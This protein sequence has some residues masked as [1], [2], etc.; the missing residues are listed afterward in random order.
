MTLVRP[1]GGPAAW[2][3]EQIIDEQTWV[4][5]CPDTVIRDLH[6][7][8]PVVVDR[9]ERLGEPIG[10][11]VGVLGPT[12]AWSPGLVDLAERVRADLVDGRGFSLVRGVPVD[13]LS[14]AGHEVACWLICAEVGVP[15]HQ[16]AARE[17]IIRVADVG[18][19]F[20]ELGVRSYETA[21]ALDYHSDSSDV[22]ALY[23]VRP[24]M[25]GGTSTI[26]SAVAVHDAVV[27]ARPDL[28]PL[29]Y[30]PWP[31]ASPVSLDVDHLPI[32]ARSDADKVFTRYGRRYIDTAADYDPSIEP[33]T[34]DQ[35]EL[36]DVY[37]GFLHDPAFALD[38]AFRPGDIQFLDN[39]SIMHARTD[40]VDW[41]EPTRR[42]EL[43][44]MWLVL[45]DLD[46]PDAFVDSGFVPRSQALAESITH[47]PV[48]DHKESR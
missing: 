48:H 26:V 35:T 21:A 9:I 38:M 18:K 10:S 47:E 23:C 17:R 11:A 22:V 24:A 14:A 30:E 15:I 6:D 5:S 20:A 42:R 16:N 41:P 36:L 34:S 28:A 32:C 43:L 7:F 46:L 45:D 12:R 31:Q 40:Y 1:G 29:L 25:Q 37:D 19:D 3:G 8:V 13:D 39:Y 33:L 44:R 4:V 27:A 2:I